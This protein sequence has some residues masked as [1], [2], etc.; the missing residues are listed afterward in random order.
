MIRTSWCGQ[1]SGEKLSVRSA[2]ATSAGSSPSAP[3]MTK[4]TAGL[5]SSRQ[6]SIWRAN[7][8][9]PRVLPCSS[10]ATMT[11]SGRLARNALAFLG[12]AGVGGRAA[13]F[14]L[15]GDLE[16]GEAQ[17]LAAELRPLE[18]AGDELALGALLHAPDREDADAH[19]R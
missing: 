2:A 9:E 17:R 11:P 6:R 1:V 19:E 14:G 8:S 15:F 10:S 3:P 13:R 7:F 16:A 4:L 18:I 5:P 12:L